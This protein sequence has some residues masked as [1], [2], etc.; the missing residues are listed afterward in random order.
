MNRRNQIIAFMLCLF[1]LPAMAQQKLCIT[2][3]GRMFT[4]ITLYGEDGKAHT[5]KA[6]ISTASEGCVI[7]SAYYYSVLKGKGKSNSDF[8]GGEFGKFKNITRVTL[9]SLSFDGRNYS[10]VK[11]L[12]APLKD[13]QQYYAVIGVSVLDGQ[14]WQ[15]NMA[16]SMMTR[17]DYPA[18][19]Q[20]AT[21]E[22]M[23]GNKKVK[24]SYLIYIPLKIQGK[25]FNCL[26]HTG[27]TGI[28]INKKIKDQPWIPEVF[29]GGD[30]GYF[31][32]NA[33]HQERLPNATVKV[34]LTKW[35]ITE[36]VKYVPMLNYCCVGNIL[37]NG[38]TYV[39][40][41]RKNRILIY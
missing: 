32:Y 14:T 31:H 9:D 19:G 17:I 22:C 25:T 38:H 15:V 6:L 28:A 11:T 12:V 4:D 35:E 41:Y 40:D 10:L 7:D 5:V 1:S 24:Q 26:F 39:L 37:F 2:N 29:E 21:I 8:V 36:T 13:K 18:K 20:V 27:A 33:R 34:P 16:A 30:F 3:D 23:R